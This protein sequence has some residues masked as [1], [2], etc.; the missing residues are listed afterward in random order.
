MEVCR[1]VLY[2]YK[3]NMCVFDF[4]FQQIKRNTIQ[5]L[6]W[7]TRELFVGGQSYYIYTIIYHQIEYLIA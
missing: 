7:I 4:D 2:A 1:A 3:N 6:K 5:M